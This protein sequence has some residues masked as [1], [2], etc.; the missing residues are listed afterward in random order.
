MIPKPPTSKEWAI[1]SDSYM[2]EWI[3]VNNIPR[4]VG[5]EDFQWSLRLQQQ[6]FFQEWRWQM[7]KGL[8]ESKGDTMTALEI[9]EKVD[10]ALDELCRDKIA[11]EGGLNDTDNE[12]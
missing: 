1:N 11:E 2:D 4:D 3:R 6:R 9:V 10:A 7:V 5:P 8:L 12:S